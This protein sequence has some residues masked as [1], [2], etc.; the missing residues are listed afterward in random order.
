[1]SP[2]TPAQ[3]RQRLIDALQL[4][5]IGPIPEDTARAEEI[6]SQAPSQWYL[7]GFLV[8]YEASPEQRS[9]ASF[10]EDIDQVSPAS[11]GDDET[12]PETASARKAFFPSSMGL[13]VLVPENAGYLTVTAQWGDYFPIPAATE[14]DQSETRLQNLTAGTWQR[15]PRKAEL[16]VKLGSINSAPAKVDIPESGGLKLVV[17][18]RPVPGGQLVPIGTLSVSIFLVN[19]RPPAPEKEKDTA[20]IF[21]TL[22]T[23]RTPGGF[24]PRPNLRGQEGNDW[25]ERVADLQYR[26]DCEYAVGHNV[27][28]T[29]PSPQKTSARKCAPPGYPPPK[30]KKW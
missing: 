4:D 27:S 7:T 20:Y 10:N 25:D 11:A 3:V 19:Y 1:M 26:H 9:D 29:A 5:L 14:T 17:S 28:A 2:A 16:T 8:P 23:V 22:L 21:Q 15:V 30:W 18:S 13:S 6:L 12:A 24:V